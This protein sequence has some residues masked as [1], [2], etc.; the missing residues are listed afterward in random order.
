VSTA[1]TTRNPDSSADGPRGS[2]WQAV[3]R[4]VRDNIIAE[5]LGQ[6]I[7]LGG[8]VLLARKLGPDE[9]GVFRV[10]LVICVLATLTNNS[11]L[12]DAL[13]QRKEITPAHEATAWWLTV[14]LAMGAALTLYAVAP[15]TAR[16][17]DMPRLGSDARLLCIPIL[18]D[19]TAVVSS[20]R[21]RR[22]LNFGA[23]ATADVL[24][25]LSFI[26]VALL[27]LWRGMPLWSLP[28]GLAARTSTRA[29]VI[30]IV[31]PHFPRALPTISAARDFSRF[32]TAA[33]G[34]GIVYILSSNADYLLV[35]RLLGSTALG[36]YGMAW[37]LL[38]F[39]PDRLHRVAGRVAFPAFC[40]LQDDSETLA[41]AYI[42][43]F[44][45][46]A[47]VV[48]PIAACAAIAAPEILRT[49]Y[50]PQWI[51]SALPMRLLAPGLA[52]SGLRLG[53]GSVYY[54]KNRPA[55]DMVLHGVRLMLLVVT[56]VGMSRWGL[57]GVSLG[58][59]GV[60]G[61][62]S[63]LGQA[64]AC[65]L[66]GLSLWTLA[67]AAIPAIRITALCALATFVGRTAALLAIPDHTFSNS[68]VVLLAA[69]VPT[70]LIYLWIE[71]ARAAD[72]LGKA[73]APA[74][75]VRA[76]ASQAHA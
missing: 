25:E 47:R 38:R 31:E 26:V 75:G 66:I 57:F 74:G 17:M 5:F 40:Q 62:V 13:V 30:W 8:F 60:E 42:D 54:S 63:V 21:L 11:G 28:A 49:I 73:F 68:S 22:R 56:V 45:Y 32:A 58:M 36:F 23:L 15:M 69:A 16:V 9:F 72:L 65:D 34:S 48:L 59:S 12:A 10:L 27:V 64:L 61:A 18:I 20:S 67:A 70:A 2:L 37:D 24:S 29:V 71:R 76:K 39:V 35:G 33:W 52:L 55:L 4:S 50:G 41:R 53:I 19:A 7:R 51:P 6:A 3:A 46:I 44:D 14:L 1:P 43:F